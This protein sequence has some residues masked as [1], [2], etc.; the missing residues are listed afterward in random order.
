MPEVE[1]EN[2]KGHER[3]HFDETNKPKVDF[4]TSLTGIAGQG[5]PGT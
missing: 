5:P 1:V 3:V 2:P 4:A